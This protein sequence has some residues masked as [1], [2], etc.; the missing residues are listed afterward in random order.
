MSDHQTSSVPAPRGSS[1]SAR[2]RIIGW[3]VL[4]TTIG[5]VAVV[6]TVRSALL[7]EVARDANADVV[8]ES[9]EVR[10]FARLGRD[11]ETARPFASTERLLDVYLSRQYPGPGEELVGYLPGTS[12]QL[13]TVSRGADADDVGPY[14][15]TD[16]GRPIV[17][18]LLAGGETSGIAATPVGEMR[19]GR[20][21]VM[22]GPA[23]DAGGALVIAQ[24]TERARQSVDTVTRTVA[25]VALGGLLLTAA[26][27]WLVA[28]AI[29]APVR[30]VRK[31]AAEISER[32]L[33][34]RIPVQGRDDI[35]ALATTFNGMLDRLEDAFRTQRQFVDD[36]S[37]EL[38]TPITIIRGHL[39]LLGDDPGERAA[40]AELVTSELD[41]MNRIVSDL[42]MLAKADRPDF[43][44]LAP[45]DVADLT[46]EIDAK[47]SAL[48]DRRWTLDR[49]ADGTALLDS[50][51]VIQAVLQLAQNAVQHTTEGAAIRIGSDFRD[52]RVA[53]WVTDTGPGVLPGEAETIFERFA[54]GSVTPAAG[55]RSGAGLGLAIVRAIADG[56]HG[57]AYVVSRPGEGATF[58]LELPVTAGGLRGADPDDEPDDVLAVEPD[59]E[60]V[61]QP[62]TTTPVAAVAV[63]S[64]RAGDVGPTTEPQGTTAGSER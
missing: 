8:Q 36:A 11:P 21:D 10:E 34:R 20:V 41:R 22:A 14:D 5:L 39:E 18:D 44:Q 25:F 60:V 1:V 33:S 29:L 16:E 2:L 62:L 26:I 24:F 51:R 37:H 32:D 47:V 38:R 30:T 9:Q 35:A 23:G 19:W 6:V 40:A 49:V 61:T 54:H 3:I 56:H 50:Q 52:D 57:S 59:T 43:V 53:F 13:L 17:L 15:L 55:S 12:P 58:G 28:G 31:A 27:A 45:V 7:A 48:G 63:P 4:T 64:P 46:L 42:L